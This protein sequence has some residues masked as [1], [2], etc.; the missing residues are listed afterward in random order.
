[1]VIFSA[2]LLAS[3]SFASFSQLQKRGKKKKRREK[4]EAE[5]LVKAFS[6]KAQKRAAGNGAKKEK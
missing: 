2:S 4:K 5:R 3:S 6:I 1:L